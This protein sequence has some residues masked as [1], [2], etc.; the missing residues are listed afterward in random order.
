MAGAKLVPAPGATEKECGRLGVMYY[1]PEALPEGVRPED[2]RKCAAHPYDRVNFWGWGQYVPSWI[3]SP[4]PPRKVWPPA[5]GKL[6]VPSVCLC[7][8]LYLTVGSVMI[9]CREPVS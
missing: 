7:N 5:Q 8:G 1:D 2:V 4:S 3:P 9:R 6:G